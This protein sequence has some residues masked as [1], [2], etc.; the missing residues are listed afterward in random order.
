M[1][2]LPEQIVTVTAVHIADGIPASHNHC[3][4]A[5]AITESY[6]EYAV[7]VGANQLIVTLDNQR[8]HLT[9]SL[10]VQLWVAS[11]DDRQIPRPITIQ[12]DFRQRLVRL[13]Y[14]EPTGEITYG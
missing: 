4:L 5:L 1:L 3:P 2:Q 13:A 12:L 10:L 11:Y 9:M 14:S 8:V 6:P 7:Y